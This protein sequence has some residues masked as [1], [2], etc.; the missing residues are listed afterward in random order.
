MARPDVYNYELVKQKLAEYIN[1]SDDPQL[2]EFCLADDVPSYD[3]INE[4]CKSD[5][6]LRQITK[7]LLDKQE[8]FLSR[9]KNI[10]PILAMFRLQQPNSHKWV[11]VNKVQMELDAN[12]TQTIKP[13]L[14]D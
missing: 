12:I 8:V 11:N 9:G 4:R 14:D 10:A 2:K 7:R 13:I 5:D 1:N 6:D 3:A